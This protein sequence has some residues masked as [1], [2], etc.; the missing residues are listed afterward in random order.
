MAIAPR[1]IQD[2][3]GYI[4]F[5]NNTKGHSGKPVKIH[6]KLFVDLFC[7]IDPSTHEGQMIIRDIESLRAK[8]ATDS[9]PS[10]AMGPIDPPRMSTGHKQRLEKIRR[11]QRGMAEQHHMQRERTLETNNVRAY[12]HIN[13]NPGDAAP[14]V[15]ISE[16]QIQHDK[17]KHAGGLYDY[18]SSGRGSK[19]LQSAKNTVLSNRDVFISGATDTLADAGKAAMQVTNSPSPALFF[20]PSQT[21]NDLHIGKQ[22]RLGSGTQKLVNDLGKI[23]NDNQGNKVSWFVQGEGAGLLSHALDK[24]AGALDGHSFKFDNARTQLPKLF[25]KLNQRK[26]QISGEFLHYFQDKQALLAIASQKQ[27]L[28]EQLGALPAG[29]G[30]D[31][32]TRRYLSERISA[33]ADNSAANQVTRQPQSLR[34]SAVTFV[35]ALRATHKAV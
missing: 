30:Y 10:P 13:Q 5:S 4:Y 9:L 33:L 32:I 18:V 7:A 6:T 25:E 1:H 22:S 21:A 27:Q 23:I 31:K 17:S 29:S 34:G 3:G 20:C 28:L 19:K 14:T 11:V 8:L 26:A 12:Y 35:D 2:I 15:Y 24:V 16:V